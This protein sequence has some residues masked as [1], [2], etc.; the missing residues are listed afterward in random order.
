MEWLLQSSL[1]VGVE[2]ESPNF[3]KQKT[4]I[5]YIITCLVLV[6]ELHS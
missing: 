2:T 3:L 5:N 1:Y 6:Y 4:Y